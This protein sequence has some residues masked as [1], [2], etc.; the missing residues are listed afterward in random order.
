VRHLKLYQFI[1]PER[2]NLEGMVDRTERENRE[3]GK[4]EEEVYKGK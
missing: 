3:T 2:G 1:L 4:K